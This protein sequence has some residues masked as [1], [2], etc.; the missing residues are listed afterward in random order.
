[1]PAG[2]VGAADLGARLL[3][4]DDPALARR[5]GAAARRLQPRAPRDRGAHPGGGDRDGRGAAAIAGAGLRC[6]GGLAS[7][8]DRHRRRAAQGALRAAGLRRRAGRRH[9]QGLGPLDRRLAARPR[10][11]RGAPGGSADQRRRACDGGRVYRCGRAGSTRCASFSPSGSA[12]GT[13]GERAGARTGDRRRAVGGRRAGRAD[14]PHRRRWRRS[15][16]PIP[17][18]ASPFPASRVAH[19]EPVG[20]GHL[21]CTLADRARRGAAARRSPSASPGRRS[22]DFS[23]RRAA[24]AIHVAGHLR[25]DT[26]RGGDAVQLLIDDA[27]PVIS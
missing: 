7:R 1:M 9:R 18:R 21:R 2:R 15:A 5:T 13:D 14:R 16:P 3:A 24:R 22:G 10:G 17:S 26:W 19:A 4:T 25:R 6:G 8:R 12:T 23:P 20:N 11:D 27:A